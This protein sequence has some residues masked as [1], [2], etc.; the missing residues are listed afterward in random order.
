MNA[1]VM[2][3]GHVIIHESQPAWR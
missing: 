3:L 1:L 2:W